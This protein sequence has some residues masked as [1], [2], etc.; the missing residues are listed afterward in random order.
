MARGAAP[1]AVRGN[2]AEAA[3]ARLQGR[4]RPAA[5]L[6]DTAGG[7]D[8]TVF[9]IPS[10]DLDEAVLN[11][12][13]RELAAVGGGSLFLVLALSS[14][15]PGPPARRGDFASCPSRGLGVLPSPDTGSRRRASSGRAVESG[16]RLA[17]TASSE[18]PRAIGVACSSGETRAR[19][20]SRVHTAV[21]RPRL[22][23]RSGAG[24]R[25]PDLRHR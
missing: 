13:A 25:H 18:D 23:A 7:P 16:R 5:A 22:R 10:I 8:G 17:A 12:H 14:S 21:Q 6:D 4:L 24:A 1:R 15:P 20:R 11:R 3:F 9:V 19:P 2:D